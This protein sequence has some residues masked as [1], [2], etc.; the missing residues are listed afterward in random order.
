M[1]QCNEHVDLTRNILASATKALCFAPDTASCTIQMDAYRCVICNNIPIYPACIDTTE[2][3]TVA[4][5]RCPPIFCRTCVEQAVISPFR[6]KWLCPVCKIQDDIYAIGIGR[7]HPRLLAP[8]KQLTVT[9]CH[10]GCDKSLLWPD[11]VN[12]HI[13]LCEFKRFCCPFTECSFTATFETIKNHVTNCAHR[14]IYCPTCLFPMRTAPGDT[15]HDCIKEYAKRFESLLNCRDPAKAYAMIHA[16]YHQKGIANGLA[17]NTLGKCTKPALHRQHGSAAPW[18]TSMLAN[19]RYGRVLNPINTNIN[20]HQLISA[21]E[22]S[23]DEDQVV[24]W[25]SHVEADQTSNSLLCSFCLGLPR[26]PVVLERHG[27]CIH[28]FCLKCANAWTVNNGNVA[29]AGE[30]PRT[31][32]CPICR[33]GDF[34]KGFLEYSSWNIT[35]KCEWDAIVIKCNFAGCNFVSSP[36]QML[37]H[38]S[39]HNAVVID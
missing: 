37:Q 28:T 11:M 9:C 32:R 26:R 22:N 13:D 8:W 10:E 34:G 23:F 19:G 18:L 14:L 29:A 30:I 36:M 5:R 15:T 1:E 7:V 35:M 39:M 27:G 31:V 3:R 24:S 25:P 6:E 2:R 4:K 12:N 20:T 21:N 33:Q 17:F 38:E 16:I